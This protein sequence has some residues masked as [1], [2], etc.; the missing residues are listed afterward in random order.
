MVAALAVIVDPALERAQAFAQTS[1][2]AV[3]ASCEDVLAHGGL[4]AVCVCVP[5]DRQRA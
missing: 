3:A 1:D 5:H 2:A 4:D